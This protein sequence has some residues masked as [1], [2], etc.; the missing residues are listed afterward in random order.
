VPGA[1]DF[2][3]LTEK[4]GTVRGRTLTYVGDGNN[5]CHA[6]IHTAV[7]LGVN[8]RV[9]SPEGYD[10]TRASSTRRCASRSNRAAK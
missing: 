10:P 4:W 6:L 2:F 1:V 7:K 9:C 5:T 3:T 8:I